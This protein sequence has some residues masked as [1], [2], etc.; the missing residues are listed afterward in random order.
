MDD[1]FVNYTL[2][3]LL[4]S[5]DQVEQDV[6]GI[7]RTLA[8]QCFLALATSYFGGE[9]KEKSLVERGLQRYG[10]ALKGLHDAMGNSSKMK[11]YD[12]LESVI[13]MSLFEVAISKRV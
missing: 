12:V 8:N 6:T 2:A 3:H 4:R 13:V 10:V 9:H 11:T 5:S 7:E 1:I